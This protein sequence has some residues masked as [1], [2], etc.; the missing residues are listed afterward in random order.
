MK[1]LVFKY[2]CTVWRNSV[3]YGRPIYKCSIKLVMVVL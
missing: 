2:V 3:Q 1:A